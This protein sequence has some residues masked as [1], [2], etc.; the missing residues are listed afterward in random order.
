MARA[1]LA[2][3]TRVTAKRLASS[4]APYSLYGADAVAFDVA[5]LLTGVP[6]S[7]IFI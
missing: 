3:S 1:P 5:R 2:G 6:S 4:S 7:G